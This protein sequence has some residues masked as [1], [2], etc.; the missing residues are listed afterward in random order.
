[1]YENI[2]WNNFERTG[3][4]ESFLEYMQIQKVKKDLEQKSQIE[5]E[6]IMNEVDKGEGDSN[7]RNNI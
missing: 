1:M 3:N 4:I 7:K 6:G 2:A 5:L